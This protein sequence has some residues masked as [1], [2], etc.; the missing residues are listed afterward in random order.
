MAERSSH[1]LQEKRDARRPVRAIFMLISGI[2]CLILFMSLSIV[3]GAV[4]IQLKTIWQSIFSFDPG[5]SL[6]QIVRGIRI[7]RAIAG[8]LVGSFLGVS[9]AVMQGLTRNPLASPSLMGVSSGASF[10]M[11]IILVV[12]P[13]ASVLTTMLGCMAG[14]G[15]GAALIFGLSFTSRART[16]SASVKLVLAGIAV[17]SLLNAVS[18]LLAI[19]FNVAKNLSFWYAGGLSGIQWIQIIFLIPVAVVGI[20]LALFLSSSITALSLGDDVARGLGQHLTLIRILGIAVILLLTGSAVSVAGTITFVGLIIP[21]IARYLFGIDYRWIIPGSAVLGAL[22]LVASD[23]ASRLI[24][25]PFETPVGVVTVLISIPF[26]LHLV[27][28]KRGISL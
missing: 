12:L 7:P 21:H 15:L 10:L 5:S 25:P 17:T 24:N 13:K 16:D 27:H 1:T 8:A 22:F 2:S 20:S 19:H 11:A 6:E 3:Y 23:T 14:A 4:P 9:G 18:S 28:R 26:F